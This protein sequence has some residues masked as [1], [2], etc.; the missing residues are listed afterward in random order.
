MAR[1]LALFCFMIASLNADY[2]CCNEGLPSCDIHCGE[3]YAS[4][5]GGAVFPC[6]NSR[7][8]SGSSSVLFSPTEV[9]TSLFSLP[10][11]VWKNKYEPGF[12][13]NAALGIHATPDHCLEAE[14]LYQNFTRK[15]SGHYNWREVNAATTALFAEN[16][17]NPLVHTSSKTNVY[18]LLAN[19]Y[20]NH[21]TCSPISLL[22]GGG[23]GV[24]WME[25]KKRDRAGILHIV[26]TTPPLNESSPTSETSTKLFGTA[27]A[28]QFK[29]GLKYAFQQGFGVSL[30]YR[31]FG[32]TRFQASNSKIVTNP[33][34]PV[35]AV[36]KIPR[37]EV[38]GL[39]NNSI[40]LSVDYLF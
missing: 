32:T 22:F 24:A 37:E 18:S 4:I 27:F 34:T 20:F 19:F 28:W 3:F 12:E 23:V 26:T 40:N 35:E 14:F 6:K 38:R 1:Y 30:N 21:N 11:V 5:G 16:F 17:N 13:I 15:I 33:G 9:G 36:F 8:R 39:L 2:Q 10:D 31:L 25:S 7:T 29:A